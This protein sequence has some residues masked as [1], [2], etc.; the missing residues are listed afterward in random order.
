[1]AARGSGCVVNVGSMVSQTRKAMDAG[2][3]ARH[4]ARKSVTRSRK[5]MA[6]TRQPR[7]MKA[8]QYS[9]QIPPLAHPVMITTGCLLSYCYWPTLSPVAMGWGAR[10]IGAMAK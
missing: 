6:T 7:A 8:C 2:V 10:G 3:F 5:S 1:M 4:M 9:Y